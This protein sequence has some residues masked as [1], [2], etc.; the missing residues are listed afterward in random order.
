MNPEGA[1]RKA[2]ASAMNGNCVEVRPVRDG[3]VEVRDSKDPD[4]GTVLLD[5]GNF[6][7]LLNDIKTGDLDSLLSG[8]A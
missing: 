6:A 1:W 8:A 3:H 4:G 2:S 7:G 5:A